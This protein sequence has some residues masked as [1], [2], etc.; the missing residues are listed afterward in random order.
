MRKAT[1]NLIIDLLA[2]LALIPI[3]I[4][5]ALAGIVVIIYNLAMR[6]IGGWD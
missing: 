4:L 6:L 3:L 1:R 2:L 5:I